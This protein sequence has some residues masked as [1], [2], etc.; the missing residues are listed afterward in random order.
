[1]KIKLALAEILYISGV[2]SI[3]LICKRLHCPIC[4]CLFDEVPLDEPITC[5]Y[6]ETRSVHYSA[7]AGR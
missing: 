5:G 3:Q 6:C 1:M 7:L 2:P 4:G